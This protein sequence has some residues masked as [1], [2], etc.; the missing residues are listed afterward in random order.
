MGR[1]RTKCALSVP[2]ERFGIHSYEGGNKMTEQSRAVSADEG[3]SR[4][5]TSPDQVFEKSLTGSSH[6]EVHTMQT[7]DQTAQQL[8]DSDED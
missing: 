5:S 1:L 6:S 8:V 2:R 4:T 7:S 3:H